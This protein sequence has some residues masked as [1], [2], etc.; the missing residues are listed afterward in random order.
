MEFRRSFQRVC[1]LTAM[2]LIASAGAIAQQPIKPVP[3]IPFGD[4]Q[5]SVLTADL[6]YRI[7]TSDS[8]IVVPAGFVTDFASTPRAIW[9]V[10]PP[11]G[12]YQLAAVVHDFLYW[13]QGCTREQADNL[14]R[15]AM[16]E[17]KVEPVKR[18]IIWQ[19]VRRFG[20]SAWDGNA[21]AKADGQPRIIPRDQ[22]DIP[23]LV[24]WPEYRAQLIG[25]G[26]RPQPTPATPPAYC[27]A[28]RLVI[29]G[30]PD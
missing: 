5:D 17:S 16:T 15:A 27:D 12:N 7:A 8:I 23:P 18:D 13:D 20:T 28:A 6:Q 24:T 26:V 4:G 10:L 19:A 1:L 29:A 9:A 3:L 22:L 25:R 21:K 2:L 11:V 14:L 30:A